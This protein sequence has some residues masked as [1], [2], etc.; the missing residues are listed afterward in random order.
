[1]QQHA[2]LHRFENSS[3]LNKVRDI[4]C[5]TLIALV[6]LLFSS[7]ANH[8]YASIEDTALDQTLDI[9]QKLG[10][11]QQ[12][13]ATSREEL[14]SLSYTQLRALRAF[15]KLPDITPLTAR[16][17]VQNLQNKP[18][19]Y[20]T[21]LLLDYYTGLP[22]AT[23]GSSWELIELL[24]SSNFV[25]TRALSSLP[26][27]TVPEAAALLPPITQIGAL[28]EAGQWAA[29][30][31]F[32]VKDIQ[33]DQVVKAIALLGTFQV[34]QQWAVEQLCRLA[35]LNG[36][37]VI[38]GVDII[39]T[40]SGSE[41]RNVHA[42]FN[43]SEIPAGYAFNWLTGFFSLT[44]EEK[45]HSFKTLPAPQK[46]IL[47]DTYSKAATDLI[48]EINNLHDVTDSFGR[49][50]GNGRLNTYSLEKLHSLFLKLHPT[51]Q[52]SFSKKLEQASQNNQKGKII[53]LLHQATEAARTATANDLTAPNM[54]ILISHGN[55]MYNS[56][57]REVLVPAISKR[58]NAHYQ[59]DLL[60]FILTVD[61]GNQFTSAFITNLA[62]KGSLT[63]LLPQSTK[64]QKKLLDLV[65]ESAFRDE[66]SL[67]L[68]SAT[69]SKLL[70]T[71]QDQA[72]SHLISLMLD[73]ID[74][75]NTTFS[76]QIQVILQYYLEK[77]SSLLSSSD[78]N[79]IRAMVARNSVI[80]LA[81][82]RQTPF[83]EW[84]KDKTLKSLSVF[85]LDD[86]GR[87]SF[88]SNCFS[89]SSN[90]Y[91][92][93]LSKTLTL[94]PVFLEM[95]K[96]LNIIFKTVERKPEHGLT[97]LFR[98]LTKSPIIIDWK[99]RLNN[100]EITHS[101]TIYRD[102]RNQRELITQFLINDYEMF[103]QRGHSYWRY[104]QLLAPLE[105]VLKS[106]TINNTQ[107]MSKQRF[108]SL[109][110]CGGIKSYLQLNKIFHN[111]VDIFGTVGS[112]KAVINNPYNRTIFEIA[113]TQ[114]DMQ[115]W[116]T[117]A[118]KTAS[119]FSVSDGEEYLQ[120]GSLPAILHKMLYRF[121]KRNGTD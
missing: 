60:S 91:I 114:P 6:S 48:R 97:Q 30:A 68:F 34:R 54:Y 103:A 16:S 39:G 79:K 94:G 31:L 113:A 117:V 119:I 78:K 85:Q 99:K 18:L 40:L 75:D 43:N 77:H 9:Y 104:H 24:G 42:L 108:L 13:A 101:V 107:I 1:M 116:D 26:R 96:E 7:L 47:L 59:G 21:V 105:A 55:E 5:I 115:S 90:G 53:L 71:L 81:E 70:Q 89:L 14:R 76:T 3:L 27:I 87:S 20:E 110:S 98:F 37:Q 8:S 17:V 121:S 66:Y 67:L 83:K 69:F 74:S 109:G 52:E 56:S 92:A 63:N 61:P 44:P 32:E 73:S 11:D 118:K 95:E 72:R 2:P 50:I 4:Y 33:F 12:P 35:G 111:K 45:E 38:Q 112:G 80:D 51:I 28:E 19:R 58:I 46:D 65:A 36:T 84:T 82:F 102:K 10:K 57:F 86:D 22:G 100:V 93:S 23:L 88:L 64:R 62:R 15:C 106:E 25:T 120:P 49:E 41:A 29:K